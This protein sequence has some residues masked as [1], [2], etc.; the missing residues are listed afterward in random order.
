MIEP[1]NLF[2]SQLLLRK[3]R[4]FASV[5]S[6]VQFGFSVQVLM[7]YAIASSFTYLVP[8]WSFAKFDTSKL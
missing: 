4:L 2:I 5:I 7:R 3:P 8:I 1:G 6:A